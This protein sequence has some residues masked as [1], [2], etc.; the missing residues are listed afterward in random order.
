MCRILQLSPETRR[1]GGLGLDFR[2]QATSSEK[3]NNPPGVGGI[4]G[5]D[6]SE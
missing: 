4:D 5:K 3:V 2:E 1:G 6:V